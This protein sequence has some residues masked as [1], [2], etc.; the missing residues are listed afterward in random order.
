ML[1]SR[2]FKEFIFDNSR[3]LQQ[4]FQINNMV[5]TKALLDQSDA[6]EILAI[7]LKVSAN[8]ANNQMVNGAT[9]VSGISGGG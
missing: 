9:M 6:N 8:I 7:L 5:A 3:F 2:K 1:K 4:G